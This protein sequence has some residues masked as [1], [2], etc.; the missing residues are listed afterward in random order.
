MINRSRI[1]SI[2][3]NSSICF[4]LIFFTS[5]IVFAED[6]QFPILKSH[7][8]E[9]LQV[10]KPSIYSHKELYG[11]ID[12]GAEIFLEYG[13]IRLFAQ[14]LHYGEKDLKL[15]IYQMTDSSAAFGIFSVSRNNCPS[16]DTLTEFSCSTSYQLA[17]ARGPYYLTIT[18]YQGTDELEN[19]S[20]KIARVVIGKIPDKDFT[21]PQIFRQSRFSPF[22]HQLKLMKGQ[23]GLQ[24]GYP[25][26]LEKFQNISKFTVQLLP[27]Q[28]ENEGLI[29]TLISLYTNSDYEKLFQNFG[30]QNLELR[31]SIWQQKSD[32]KG[33]YLIKNLADQ[34]ILFIQTTNDF[35][36]LYKIKAELD[37]Y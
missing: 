15:E 9:N 33:L 31:Q 32:T 4:Y 2:F 19:L 29:C 37:K 11:Y 30:F 35:K 27:V 14:E 25:D 34:K 13:F 7:E 24:N 26:W 1:H 21:I 16:V 18:N 20:I 12:G 6:I 36:D 23:L 8:I 3:Q 22:L 17:L 28:S 5:N 10:E